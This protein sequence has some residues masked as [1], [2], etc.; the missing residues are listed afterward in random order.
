MKF[1]N[2]AL[3]MATLVFVSSVNAK[4][5]SS[6]Y[7]WMSKKEFKQE[8]RSAVK[9]AK[10]N[11]ASTNEITDDLMSSDM[12]MFRALV[13][14]ESNA[15]I[16]NKYMAH[17]KDKGV[18]ACSD[19]T[20]IKNADEVDACIDYLDENYETF[21]NDLKYFAALLVPL[22]SF[23][24]FTYKMYPL[25]KREK[26]TH[27]VVVTRVFDFASFMNVNLPTTEWKAGF[28]YVSEPHHGKIKRFSRS[29]DLQQYLK[30]FVYEDLLKAAKRIDELELN[31]KIV[32]DHKLLY[33]LASFSDEFKR[34]R[35]IGEAERLATLASLHM[36]MSWISKFNSFNVDGLMKVT[37]DISTLY[38]VDALFW[39]NVDGVTAQQ[40]AN[41]LNKKKYKKLYTI[42]PDGSSTLDAAF[43]HQKEAIFL[44]IVAWEELKNRSA[45]ELDIVNSLISG[46]VETRTNRGAE[47]LEELV[48]GKTEIRSDITGETIVVDLPAF[49]ANAPDDLKIMMPNAFADSKSKTHNEKKM[50]EKVIKA[51]D[52]K[53]YKTTYRNYYY[54]R[55]VGWNYSAFKYLFPE[56]KEGDDV[57]KYTRILNQST[58]GLPVASLMNISMF[59]NR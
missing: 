5:D 28:S 13:I 7:E 42:L 39:Q 58:G 30:V 1:I 9:R 24:S 10:R 19:F 57:A 6:N 36:G 17:F 21:A 43:K 45:D 53:S 25:V 18:S 56:M 33:G 4:I 32:W 47:K 55:A 59:Y 29:K 16:R 35:Y 41:V 54:G 15:D 52:G 34:Y 22:R 27:S 31:T 3:G 23:K 44:R 37:K 50:L 26:I 20:G 11:V 38:G 49:Y 46:A 48:L 2:L 8:K 12:K 40:V 14:G 51:K